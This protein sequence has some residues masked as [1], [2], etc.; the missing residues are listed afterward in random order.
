MALNK[1]RKSPASFILILIGFILPEQ[2]FTQA[3]FKKGYIVTRTKDTV[4]GLVDYRNW[5]RNPSTIRFSKDGQPGEIVNYIPEMVLAIGI[6]LPEFTEIY[7]SSRIRYD[8][9]SV[10]LNRLTTNGE[11]EFKEANVFLLLLA[12]GE[13]ALY[14]YKRAD[15]R[16]HFFTGGRDET[17]KELV[18]H[19]YAVRE[20]SG[21]QINQLYKSQ[22]QELLSGCQNIK[23]TEFGN[24]EYSQKQIEHLVNRFNNCR[25]RNTFS[26]KPGKN[27][28]LFRLVAG[29]NYSGYSIEGF[30]SLQHTYSKSIL[31]A[32]GFSVNFIFPRDEKRSSIYTELIVKMHKHTGSYLEYSA[33]NNYVNYEHTLDFT[34][35]KFNT[36][37]RHR[38]GRSALNPFIQFGFSNGIAL[39]FKGEQIMHK[40]FYAT[41]ETKTSKID[42]LNRKYELGLIGGFGISLG[43]RSSVDLRIEGSNGATSSRALSSIATSFFLLYGFQL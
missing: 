37:Y 40:V 8:S 39:K 31:P 35:L 16:I 10:N 14:R 36:L 26:Y 20:G 9:S 6:R 23:S 33:N 43:K 2:A 34:Y 19:P 15:G 41:D 24:L 5:D 30:P 3:N 11:P 32:F 12:D 17:P 27:P 25:S 38:L 42:L 7:H 18:N 28:P 21:S 13:L 4:L 1:L 22:L 29:I